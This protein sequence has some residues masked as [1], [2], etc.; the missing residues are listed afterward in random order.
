MAKRS[1][2]GV[3]RSLLGPALLGATALLISGCGPVHPGAAAVVDGQ[4][5][6]MQQVDETAS[7]YCA[8]VLASA[9]SQGDIDNAQIRQRSVMLLVQGEVADAIADEE[10][11]EVKVP[12]LGAAERAQVDAAF[13][14]DADDVVTLIQRDQRTSQIAIALG[15]EAGATGG[16][17]GL[18][19]AGAQVLDQALGDA[20]VSIDPRFGLSSDNQP[21]SE[22]GVS[23]S[24]SVPSGDLD[25]ATAEDRPDALTCS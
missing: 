3:P 7:A 15:R 6:S 10:G 25:A 19:A 22:I 11:L 24:L 13:G 20:D 8:Y 1:R 5:V 21:L 2:L 12:A 4:R 14:R 17:E 18:F 9:Q 23:G 16:D